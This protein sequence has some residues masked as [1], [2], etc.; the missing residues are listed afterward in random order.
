MLNYF[1]KKKKKMKKKKKTEKTS[2]GVLMDE[3]LTFGMINNC[4]N[5]SIYSKKY[6]IKL[7]LYASDT[8]FEQRQTT[9]MHVRLISLILQKRAARHICKTRQSGSTLFIDICILNV[10]KFEFMYKY[11]TDDLPKFI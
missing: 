3:K 6:T 5:W 4:N 2:F 11:A 8:I 7:I 10:Y 1:L 9:E